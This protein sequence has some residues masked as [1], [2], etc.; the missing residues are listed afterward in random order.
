M[1]FIVILGVLTAF[2]I[3]IAWKMWPTQTGGG[4]IVYVL[5]NA[6]KKIGND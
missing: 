6:E 1:E 5:D 4:A 2:G 3:F